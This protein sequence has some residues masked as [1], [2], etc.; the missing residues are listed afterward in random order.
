MALTPPPRPWLIDS[1]NRG[2]PRLWARRWLPPPDLEEA[3]LDAQAIRAT[4]LAD[5]GDPWFRG[6]LRVLLAALKEEAQLNPM[7]RML[8]HGQLLKTLKERLWAQA[9][10]TAHPEIRQRPI[11]APVVIVGPMRSGTTRLH[12]LLA[13]DP[14]F[15]HLKLHE[16][17]CPAP[18]PS[19][20]KRRRDPRI[21]YTDR[22]WRALTWINPGNAAVHPTGAMEPDE[23][24]GLLENSIWGA[25]IE[26]QRR[27]PSYAR[28]CEATDAT[29]AYAHMAD[30]LRLA[31]WFRGDDP[32]TTWLLKTPQHMQDL[33]A[34]LNIFPDARLIFI[35]RDPAAVVGSACS[36]AWHQ[37]VVQSDAVD[38]HWIG[39]EWLHK[40]G[41]RIET[42]LR[43]RATVPPARQLDL[44][45]DEMNGDWRAAMR[46]VYAFLDRDMGA[47]EPA[48]AA[49][50]G[51]EQRHAAHR[52]ELADYGL[53]A[54]AIRSRFSEYSSRFLA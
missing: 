5:F 42:T 9:L 20:L 15:A 1:A 19:S 14:G 45:F 53:D 11:V 3:T 4:G 50:L 40:T 41:H 16:A 6:P 35:H 37:M 23:E 34:L 26:A 17:M 51:R 39:A 48:M 47:V 44:T 8:A 27:V 24:L 25:M 30:L 33:G 49:Y 21:A 43:V 46:R 2:L 54:A 29:P 32:A 18:W 38:P 52:Y 36:L 10:F 31:G 13:C 22:A 12:R 7:G 28:W